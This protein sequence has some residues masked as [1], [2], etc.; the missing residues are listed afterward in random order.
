M[1]DHGDEFIFGAAG[2]LGLLAGGALAGK[3]VG[4]LLFSLLARGDVFH[5]GNEIERLLVRVSEERY[6]QVDPHDG[7]IFAQVTLFH[8]VGRN[9]AGC[10]AAGHRPIRFDV[11]RVGDVGKRFGAQLFARVA[12]DGA[13]RIIK[14]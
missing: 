3:Q 10:Q 7:A 5:N 4:A 11:I 2:R 6:G 8:R 14:S 12:G 9:L 1:R 13:D